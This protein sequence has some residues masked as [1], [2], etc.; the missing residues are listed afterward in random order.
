MHGDQ[1]KDAVTKFLKNIIKER[2]RSPEVQRG[3]FLDQAIADLNTKE[4]VTEDFIITYLFGILFAGFDSTSAVL[5]SALNLLQEN[6]LVLQELTVY[7]TVSFSVND[8]Y[9]CP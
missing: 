9:R 3:D 1:D 4:F 2:L 7:Y 5:T 8:V 6:P